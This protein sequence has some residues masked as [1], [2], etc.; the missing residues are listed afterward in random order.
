MQRLNENLALN[1]LATPQDDSLGFDFADRSLSR[2]QRIAAYDTYRFSQRKSKRSSRTVECR[3]CSDRGV[4]LVDKIWVIDAHIPHGIN[5]A[6]WCLYNAS[7]SAPRL[8]NPHLPPEEQTLIYCDCRVR[9]EDD[10][11]QHFQDIFGQ[12]ISLHWFGKMLVEHRM[13]RS[14]Q[15]ATSFAEGLA[16]GAMG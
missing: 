3:N 13:V 5:I 9:G 2:E 4:V 15:P 8:Y 11:Q 14:Q 7:E 6:D 1:A 12:H 10:K 16:G